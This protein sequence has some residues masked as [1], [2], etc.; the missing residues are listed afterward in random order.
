M[1]DIRNPLCPSQICGYKIMGLKGEVNLV[2][3]PDCLPLSITKADSQ[4][5]HSITDLLN[6]LGATPMS[7][8]VSSNQRQW[9]FQRSSTESRHKA[10][11]S[12]FSSRTSCLWF[13][14]VLFP[15]SANGWCPTKGAM[16]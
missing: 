1:C 12:S 10:L 9:G 15:R 6:D 2:A 5:V 4:W 14:S 16:A 3:H 13:H 7:V 8:R 11:I